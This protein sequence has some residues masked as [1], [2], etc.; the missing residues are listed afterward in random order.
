MLRIR[1]QSR[2]NRNKKI[3]YGKEKQATR[4]IYMI[5]EGVEEGSREG[6]LM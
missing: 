1:E 6:P 2:K 4:R 3:Y 5:S